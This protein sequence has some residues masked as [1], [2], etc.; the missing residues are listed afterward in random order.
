MEII[1]ELEP[2][3]RRIYTGIIGY[4]TPN[5]DMFFNVAIRTLLFWEGPG[6]GRGR[7]AGEMGV[8]G[9][10]T[11][12]STPEGEYEECLIKSRFLL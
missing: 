4:I 8:G 11:Y 6:Q 5:R 12:Y 9:G 10:I 1:R 7:G 2:E 3:E